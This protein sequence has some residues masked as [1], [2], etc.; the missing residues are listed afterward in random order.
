MAGIMERKANIG[1]APCVAWGNASM[2]EQGN[3]MNNWIETAAEIFYSVILPFG[4]GA[5]VLIRWVLG[6]EDKPEK[7]A[8]AKSSIYL[9]LLWTFGALVIAANA[10]IDIRQD[11]KEVCVALEKAIG[12]P[13]MSGEE[14]DSLYDTQDWW[15][16]CHPEDA[17]DEYD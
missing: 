14:R 12:V 4:P 16:I 11:R 1:K 8:L 10:I 17:P 9:A 3:A 7:K 6:D 5:Y 15:T 2:L 13:A